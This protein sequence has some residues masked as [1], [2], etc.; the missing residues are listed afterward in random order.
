MSPFGVRV[1]CGATAET[2]T[3]EATGDLIRPLAADDYGK[4]G[5]S[6]SILK[7]AVKAYFQA[8][9]SQVYLSD[10][11]PGDQY[12]AN[13]WSPVTVRLRPVAARVVSVDAVLT[14]LT[15]KTLRNNSKKTGSFDASISQ[16]V[17]ET[18]DTNWSQSVSFAVTQSINYG[19]KFIGGDTSVSF[20]TDFQTGGSRSVST[21]MGQSSGVMVDLDPGE[22]VVAKLTASRGQMAVEVVYDAYLS[23]VIAAYYDS[24]YKWKHWWPVDITGALEA[25]DKPASLSVTNV[26]DAVSFSGGEIVLEEVSGRRTRV[27]ATKRPTST[28]EVVDPT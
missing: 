27:P 18:V 17:S 22:S 5:L 2:T 1:K 25:I 3:V 24:V 7:D 23:G 21:S 6:D 4:Y 14:A 19:I 12:Q 28:T 10:P 8:R 15:E 13:N 16:D 26:I 11:T 20:T 9:P